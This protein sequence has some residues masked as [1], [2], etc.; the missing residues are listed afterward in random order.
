MP[1]PTASVRSLPGTS[2]D[3][4]GTLAVALIAMSALLAA[5]ALFIRRRARRAIPS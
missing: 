3:D 5:G 1:T 4:R 2:A